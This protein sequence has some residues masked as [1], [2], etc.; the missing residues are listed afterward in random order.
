MFLQRYNPW[1]KTKR[2]QLQ[3]WNVLQFD[4][5]KTDIDEHID[6]IDTLGDLIGQK[7]EAKMEKICR[8]HAYYNTDTPGNLSRLAKDKR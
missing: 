2:E 8:Y 4:P 6:L 1:G 7:Y 5:Q 3:S